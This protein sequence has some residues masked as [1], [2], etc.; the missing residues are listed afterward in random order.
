MGSVGA[1]CHIS[2]E[3]SRGICEY[4]VQVVYDHII[5]RLSL[6]LSSRMTPLVRSSALSSAF[7]L[8]PDLFCYIG[9][10]YM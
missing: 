5:L 9:H 6:W 10:V 8:E 4:Q 2:S 7:P 3:R 1:K